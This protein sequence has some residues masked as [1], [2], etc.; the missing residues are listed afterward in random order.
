MNCNGFV[1]IIMANFS[2]KQVIILVLIISCTFYGCTENKKQ[3]ALHP[4]ECTAYKEGIFYNK[5]KTYKIVRTANSQVEYDLLTNT[6]YYF[7]VHWLYDCAYNLTFKHTTNKTDTFA[8]KPND[9]LRIQFV[10]IK[11]NSITYEVDFKNERYQN[12]MFKED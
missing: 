8:L 1:K 4:K 9:L 10:A 7:E 11:N 5:D 6:A 2:Y 12:I 3:N